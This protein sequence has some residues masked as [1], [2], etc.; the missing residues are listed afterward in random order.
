MNRDTDFPVPGTALKL[1]VSFVEG[2]AEF[3]LVWGSTAYRRDEYQRLNSKIQE[4]AEQKSEPVKGK[5]VLGECCLVKVSNNWFRCRVLHGRVGESRAFLLDRG[6]TLL[7]EPRCLR[8]ASPELFQLPPQVRAFIL[9]NLVSRASDNWTAQTLTVLNSM[10][11]LEVVGTVKTLLPQGLVLLD[12]PALSTQ[13]LELGLAKVLPESSF[14]ALLDKCLSTKGYTLQKPDNMSFPPFTNLT[15]SVEARVTPRPWNMD[16]FYPQLQIG[17][18]EPVLVTQVTDPQRIFCQ[19]RSLS[20]EV[21]RL[22]ESMYHYYEL[23]SS[24][25]EPDFSRQPLVLGQPYASRGSDGH[26]YRSLLQEYFPDKQLALVI[27]VDWGRRDVVPVNSLRLLV[28]DYFRMPVVTFPCSLYGVSDVGIGWEPSQIFE[29][30][31]LLQG[32]HFNAKIEFYNPY[33]HAYVITLFGEDGLNLNCFY[34][35]QAQSL[36]K[37][38]KPKAENLVSY[39]AVENTAK[40]DPSK[41]KIIPPQKIIPNISIVQLKV[42]TF[43]DALVEYVHDPSNFWIRTAEN[44]TKYCEMMEAIKNLYSQGSKLDG[45]ITKPQKGQLCCTKF[46]DDQYYRAAVLCTHGKLVDVYF[47]DHGNTEMV[48]WYNIK[49]LPAAFKE[50]PGL[51]IHCCLADLFPLGESWSQEAVLA[52]KVAVVDKKLVVYVVSK[53][54][55]KYIIDLLDHSRIEERNVGKILAASGHAK[56]EESDIVS[57]EVQFPHIVPTSKTG[58]TPNIQTILDHVGVDKKSF[59]KNK[60]TPVH[61]MKNNAD[62]VMHSPYKEQLFEPG[63]TISVVVSSIDSPG[64]FWCQNAL[65]M[66]ELKLLMV[67]IQEY[68]TISNCPYECSTPACIAKCSSDGKWYRALITGSPSAT[69]NQE[70][71]EVFLVDYGRKKNVPVQDLRSIKGGLLQVKSFAFKCSLYNLISP[72]NSNPLNWSKSVTTVFQE[73][74]NKSSKNLPE[75]YCTV[76]GQASL[77]EERFNIVDLFTPFKSICCLLV[78]TGFALHLAHK[79]LIPSVQLHSFY[80]SMHD[81][82]TGSEEEIYITHVNSSLEF[83]CQLSKNVDTVNLISSAIAKVCKKAKQSKACEK[84]VPLCLA[85]FTDKQWYRGFVASRGPQT[86]VFFVDFG[87]TEKMLKEDLIPIPSDAYE[88]L[89]SPMQ[90]IKCSLSDVP[91]NVPDEVVSWFENTVLDKALKALVVAKESDGKLI[92]ELYDGNLQINAKLKTKLGV[93]QK[94]T[95][96]SQSVVLSSFGVRDQKKTVNSQTFDP[97][98]RIRKDSGKHLSYESKDSKSLEVRCQQTKQSTVLQSVFQSDQLPQK[99]AKHSNISKEFPCERKQNLDRKVTKKPSRFEERNNHKAIPQL[100]KLSDLPKREIFSGSQVLVY[101][102]H[103]NS[104]Y[105]FYVQVAED[106]QLDHISDILNSD[107]RSSEALDEKDVNLGDLLCAFFE[108]DEYY[109]RAVVTEK[110]SNRLRVEYIDYGNTSIINANKT[111]ML[112]SS[113]LSIPSMSIHCYLSGIDCSKNVSCADEL[114]QKFNEKTRENQ[115]NCEFVKEDKLKWEIILH[116]QDCCINNLLTSSFENPLEQFEKLCLNDAEKTIKEEEITCF[117]WMLPQI[118]ETVKAYASS[119]DGPEYFWCQLVTSEIDSLAIKVQEAGELSSTDI[120]LDL[121]I[122]IGSPCNVKYSEDDNWYRA[123]VTKIEA[124]IVTVRF[125]DY[126]NEDTVHKERVQ[127]LPNRLLTIPPQAF[128]CCLS[129]FDFLEGCWNSEGLSFFCDKVTEDILEIMLLKI[130]ENIVCKMPL[131]YVNIQYNGM[132]I[133]DEMAQFWEV[134]QKASTFVGETSSDLKTPLEVDIG[135]EK[136]CVINLGQENGLQES[137]NAKEEVSEDLN[138]VETM[139]TEEKFNSSENLEEQVLKIKIDTFSERATLNSSQN[140][141]QNNVSPS[142]TDHPVAQTSEES[143]TNMDC[144]VTFDK[145]MKNGDYG[146]FADENYVAVSDELTDIYKEPRDEY[147]YEDDQQDDL[148][149]IPDQTHKVLDSQ[150][151]NLQEPAS[152]NMDLCDPEDEMKVDVSKIQSWVEGVPFEVLKM[153][154][155]NKRKPKPVGGPKRTVVDHFNPM[156]LSTNEDS[157]DSTNTSTHGSDLVSNTLQALQDA[158]PTTVTP[159]FILSSLQTLLEAHHSSFQSQITASLAEM[160]RDLTSTS[161][162]VDTIERKQE[163]M[164]V[165]QGNV[166]AYAQSLAE[167]L[168]MLEVADA[169]NRSRRNNLRLRGIPESISSSDLVT[170]LSEFFNHLA[171]PANP[172]EELQR[173]ATWRL[174]P[175]L[176]SNPG[177][178]ASITEDIT[179]FLASNDNGEVD[180]FTLWA[181]LKAYIRGSFIK[182]A[183][184][185]KKRKGET[186]AQLTMSLRKISGE[187][188]MNPTDT[189]Q[190]TSGS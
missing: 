81:I 121:N 71:V 180:D 152:D 38:N 19:L 41:A 138:I 53:E 132:S 146:E 6:C 144:L 37:D 107:K 17:V 3:I 2:I 99:M 123:V 186:L 168:I 82:K 77:H 140:S 160:R 117:Q 110:L 131:V 57:A 8:E 22:S 174:H 178:E 51:A 162:R 31:S 43:Y 145:E 15:H 116:D 122:E 50:M 188:K 103:I 101:V 39:P 12:L 125:I 111:Y 104:I 79:N 49:E 14:R 87:N 88:L 95:T 67:D 184:A 65:H 44:A 74:V 171:P 89:L 181:A 108:D 9:W 1:Q 182:I 97:S 149:A 139:P 114:L 189:V 48:D 78:E 167:Q 169:E 55:D 72:L 109:Y 63:T 58:I 170:H 94:N 183:A 185:E 5:A 135:L 163:D 164:I 154:Q 66:Y 83:F 130:Q 11:N 30:R 133:N 36:R 143:G 20:N 161:E 147:C 136:E 98:I 120:N 148:Q 24:C 187:H 33:E 91:Q 26:W 13:L 18:T 76:F 113:L 157:Q 75:F 54:A 100:H 52:F 35:M 45:I 69:P 166:L 28:A 127:K 106:S 176:F 4:I 179:E 153:A 90:A 27:Y 105:D 112:E 92:I 16:Y 25:G 59:C 134:K 84:T 102:S 64:V 62:H 40:E 21:Q 93:D 151:D 86:E 10:K 129:G 155:S 70:T 173:A 124:D 42:S 23:Q 73:F 47:I 158:A 119:V 175:H 190:A 172:N 159:S 68:C 61:V 96:N 150:D 85:K 165:E 80:Y 32:R 137:I 142:E 60:E 46:K 177:T 128:P 118:G 34:G 156:I 115:L 126:G 29:L 7:V 141:L 56:Y